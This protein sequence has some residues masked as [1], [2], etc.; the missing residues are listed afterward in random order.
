MQWQ[1]REKIKNKK[2]RRGII[3]TL[4][5]GFSRDADTRIRSI[6][7]AFHNQNIIYQ[8]GLSEVHVQLYIVH[9]AIFGGCGGSVGATSC[10]QH[11]KCNRRPSRSTRNGKKKL[12]HIFHLVDRRLRQPTLAFALEFTFVCFALC[13]VSQHSVPFHLNLVCRA[14]NA[15]AAVEFTGNRDTR[16]RF[17][18][19]PLCLVHSQNYHS[20]RGSSQ[21][22]PSEEQ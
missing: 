12:L 16:I 14:V 13:A 19:F 8:R 7:N 18:F 1:K 15:A 10:H 4:T 22:K 17:S 6:A 21:H 11:C 2:P 20:P 3:A 9:F 5:A